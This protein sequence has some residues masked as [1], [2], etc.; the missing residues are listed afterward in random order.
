MKDTAKL[1]YIKKLY[2]IKNT[3][4]QHAPMVM[5]T[6][7][8]S[9]RIGS[10]THRRHSH[11]RTGVEVHLTLHG[12][13]TTAPPDRTFYVSHTTSERIL[14]GIVSWKRNVHSRQRIFISMINPITIMMNISGTAH[15]YLDN[16]IFNIVYQNILL[17][18]PGYAV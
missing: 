17:L 12:A 8:L 10:S 14:L 2:L 5:P 18:F 16:F 3:Y 4:F 15:E 13:E 7:T 6:R 1:E 9:E 11:R